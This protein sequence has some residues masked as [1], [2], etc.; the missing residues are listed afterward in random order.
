MYM[1]RPMKT[2]NVT[3]ARRELPKILRSV[4]LGS[5]PVLVGRRGEGQAVIVKREEYE[6]LAAQSRHD[7]TWDDLRLELGSPEDDLSTAI[8]ELRADNRAQVEGRMSRSV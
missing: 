4:I 1:I 5:G 2:L 7:V 3:E 8:A 6:A